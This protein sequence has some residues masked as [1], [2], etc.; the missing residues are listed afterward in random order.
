MSTTP[1]RCHVP[2][3]A[4][5]PAPSAASSEPPTG[6]AQAVTAQD[7]WYVSAWLKLRM[8]L[9]ELYRETGRHAD[10]DRV[11]AELRALLA[12]ADADHPLWPRLAK[13]DR[14]ATGKGAIDTQ[15]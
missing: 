12:V 4:I 2:A 9:A 8:R 11:C 3:S 6:R 15:R 14:S 1:W 13:V 5:S 7:G 10:A